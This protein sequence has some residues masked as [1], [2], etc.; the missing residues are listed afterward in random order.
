MLYDFL[1]SH[2][3]ELIA[4]CKKKVAKRYEPAPLPSVIDHGV[5][6]FLEQLCHTLNSEQV[7]TVRIPY[8]PLR[9]PVDSPIG[10]AATLHGAELLRLGYTVDQVVHHYGDVCQ[11]VT[12]LAARRGTTISVDEFRTLNRCLDEAIADA[13]T[14]FS[15]A[16]EAAI[17]NQAA[18]LHGRIGDL[19]EEQRRLLDIAVQTL[20]AIQS[21]KVGATGQ[22]SAALMGT[23]TELRG[24]IDRTLPEIR[25]MSGLTKG[26]TRGATS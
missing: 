19:A 4:E 24:L 17:F 2:R 16:R 3:G 25:L 10:H 26:P 6:L 1:I 14:A 8:E 23:L 18:D 20:G 15:D 12:D 13:V 5:P 21:G 11:A 22:T 9:S 7:T